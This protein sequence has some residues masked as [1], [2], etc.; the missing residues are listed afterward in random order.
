MNPFNLIVVSLIFLS[1]AVIVVVFGRSLS[2][3][4]GINVNEVKPRKE[5]KK[6]F[7]L[8]RFFGHV[9][10]GLKGVFVIF[11]EWV[12]RNV[13]KILH[14]VHFWL[15]K[16]KKKK[17][18]NGAA[19]ELEA[20][21]ELILQEE[22]NLDTVINENLGSSEEEQKIEEGEREKMKEVF[23]A[24]EQEVVIPES[25][26]QTEIPAQ[27]RFEEEFEQPQDD[28]EKENK[29]AKFFSWKKKG[30]DEG[31][32][33]EENEGDLEVGLETE[34]EEIKSEEI[35]DTSSENFWSK[36]KNRIPFFSKGKSEE[37]E[38]SQEI[39][40]E[41]DLS[42]QFSDGVVKVDKPAAQKP[43]EEF[44]IKEVVKTVK[45]PGENYDVDDELG[46]DRKILEKKILQKISKEPKNI[47]HYRQLG[48]LYI[49]MGSFEDATDT[50]KFILKVAPRDA[51]SKRKIEKIKLLKRL[52]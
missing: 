52:G 3:V 24:E 12:V 1:L 38:G 43:Q 22:K 36:M 27:Q 49:K 28:P 2:R 39:V 31:F 8:F 34:I 16:T 29:I 25:Q 6:K 40:Q 26:Q 32:L 30:K 47:E 42:E 51:D 19:D 9:A 41:R 46:V 4:K 5:K 20:K 33:A 44:L 15:I 7:F 37:G 10:G 17:S 14:L 21:K 48:E 11:A 13:K 50:Y 23:V 18:G 45:D 35:S